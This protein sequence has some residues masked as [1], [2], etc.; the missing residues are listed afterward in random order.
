MSTQPRR[1]LGGAVGDD[2]RPRVAGRSRS[3]DDHRT[4]HPHLPGGWLEDRLFERGLTARDL[5]QLTGLNEQTVGAARHSRSI[6]ARTLR[7]I[8]RALQQ[9]P[10]LMESLPFGKSH[11]ELH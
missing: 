6:S 7:L 5:A 8:C 9:V 3:L 2:G 1:D 4:S 10:I 11:R